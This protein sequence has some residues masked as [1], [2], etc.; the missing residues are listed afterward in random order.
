MAT[1]VV[2]VFVKVTV[3][4]KPKSHHFKSDRDEIWHNFCRV[5]SHLL[6]QS[7]L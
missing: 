7:D 6:M 1:H 2:L 5:N 4:I 3:F